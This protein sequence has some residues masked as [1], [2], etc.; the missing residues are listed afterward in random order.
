MDNPI[1]PKNVIFYGVWPGHRSGH[2]SWIAKG[3]SVLM[4]QGIAIDS[5]HTSPVRGYGWNYTGQ[6]DQPQGYARLTYR[7]TSDFKP[8]TVICCWDRT[9]DSR[10][11]S[12]AAFLAPG[13]HTAEALLTAARAAFPAKMDQLDKAGGINVKENSN[14]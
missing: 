13:K 10:F 5:A 11:G 9:E 1:D 14:E 3:S 2:R 12:I 7:E 8:W 4:D 6:P